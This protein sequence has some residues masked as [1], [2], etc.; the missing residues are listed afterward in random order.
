MSDVN[1]VNTVNDVP[2]VQVMV[3]EPTN[4]NPAP[5]SPSLPSMLSTFATTPKRGTPRRHKREAS[6]LLAY[7]IEHGGRVDLT[8][9][10]KMELASRGLRTDRIS[11]A[12]YDVRKYYGKTVTSQRQGRAVS[13]YVVM[14]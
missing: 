8:P 6:I 4:P 1:A 11:C 12:A 5:A 3:T 2:T 10:A 14:L 13:A 7:A 9:E